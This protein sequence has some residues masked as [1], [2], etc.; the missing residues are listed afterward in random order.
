MYIFNLVSFS[1][2]NTYNRIF[3]KF[4]TN[5]TYKTKNNLCVVTG[6]SAKYFDPLTQQYYLN[7]ES[8]KIIREKYFQKEEES[9][10]FRIQTLSDLA[11]QKKEKLRKILLSSGNSNKGFMDVINKIG[12]IKSDPIDFE[13]RTIACKFF[14]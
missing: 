9:L 11:S 2:V 3:S 12:I 6:Q 5:E 7:I 4:K 13:K 14:I 10:L 8:F 1:N